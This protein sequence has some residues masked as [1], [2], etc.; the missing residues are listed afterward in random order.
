MA[1]TPTVS[2][3]LID[4][5]SSRNLSSL[6]AIIPFILKYR[7]Q[8][9]GALIALVIASGTVLA[10]GNGLRM[11]V[12]EGFADGDGGLLD[13][14]LFVLFAV[15]L[16]LAGASYMRFFL[17]SWIGE[18]VVADIRSAVYRHII[19]LDSEFFE[20][21]RTGEVL[22]RLTTDTTLLQSVIGSSVS[23]ALRNALMFV[24]GLTMLAITSP[25]LTALVLLVVPL[26]VVP[27]VGYGRRVRRLSRESQDRIADV[28]AFSE[29]TLNALRTV[30]AYTHEEIE[31]TRFGT[32]VE[33]AFKTAVA[34]ISARAL[35]TAIVIVM[36]FGAVGTI[37]WIG[38]HDVLDGVI[39]AGEL[40]AFVFYAVVVA[41]S[42]GAISEVIGDL[43]RAAGA[44][45]RLVA[46]LETKPKIA[47]PENPVA[48][49]VPHQGHVSFEDVTFHYP[50]RP[51]RSAL[52]GLNLSVRP[53]ETVALVG[54]SGAGKT[55]VF[56]LLLRFYDPASGTIRVDG[57]DVRTADPVAVRERIGLVAQDP[58]IFAANAWDN[59]RYG[60]P[61]ASDA[62]V[63]AAADAAHASE[64]LDRLPEGFGTY[65]GE[66]GIR[67]SGGQ[68]QRIAIARAILRN[69]SIL[70]LDEATSALDAESEQV[71]QQALEGIMKERTTLVIAHRL[72]TVLHADRIAV[73]D[74]GKL[75]AIG[76]HQE[77]LETS[78]LYGRLAKLQFDRDAA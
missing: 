55:T 59:I 65:L 33:S 29:E 30:Q 37:L 11:L 19:R 24:G 77:L 18:R 3:K 9:I 67:L 63:R 1:R 42:V 21:T 64:F 17:V 16:L 34:R 52:E 38:G 62:D 58:V 46:L 76:T 27:I 60:R 26:V 5:E 36:V 4:R 51:D 78:P 66:K 7:L 57:V 44:A 14:A 50:A 20:V 69:P 71:V 13:R 8:L 12:D 48:M 23:I 40:S 35:L 39:S 49:P 73:I 75:V 25:K 45:E 10:L 43:Q 32:H 28:S 41:G 31:S 6:R 68:R 72:A 74:D 70:L 15:T 2:A 53:G 61:G 54:P 56:Q 47:A 22:S